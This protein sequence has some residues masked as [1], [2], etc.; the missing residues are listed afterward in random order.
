M[1]TPTTP[2]PMIGTPARG[3]G[4]A[5]P[6]E[7]GCGTMN[8]AEKRCPREARD[9]RA[10]GPAG[11]RR[12]RRRVASSTSASRATWSRSSPAA[13]R[14]WPGPR[15]SSPI[16]GEDAH[17]LGAVKLLAPL[18]PPV[19]LNSGQNYWDH[20]DEKPEVDQKEPG[21]LPQDAVRGDRAGRARALRLDRDEEARLRGRARGRDRQARPPHPGRAARSTTSSATRSRTTSPPATA[22]PFRIRRAAGSTR[23]GRGRTSTPRRRSAPGS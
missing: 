4:G 12:R 7:M 5:M 13:T 3:R 23:S 8:G 20:R 11:A 18:V 2:T 10:R 19:I 21:V 17:P 1:L 16:P 9:L 14:R 22:R 15:A 6:S